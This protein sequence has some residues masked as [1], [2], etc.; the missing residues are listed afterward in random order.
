MCSGTESG[1]FQ[2]KERLDSPD[3][4]R[5]DFARVR[6]P[7]TLAFSLA[8]TSSPVT[9]LSRQ[10]IFL[11]QSQSEARGGPHPAMITTPELSFPSSFLTALVLL[12]SSL[13]RKQLVTRHMSSSTALFSPVCAMLLG[14]LLNLRSP[15]QL[16]SPSR[17]VCASSVKEV[18]EERCANDALRKANLLLSQLYCLALSGL[19]V[20]LGRSTSSPLME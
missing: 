11:F 4:E 9:R 6:G 12:D 2:R 7:L 1:Q 20:A 14:S 8:A 19:V 17:L 10:P 16:T 18:S 3:K 15:Y 13:S 5:A